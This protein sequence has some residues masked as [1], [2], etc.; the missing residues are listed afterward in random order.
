MSLLNLLYGAVFG[1][2]LEN[3][4]L[5]WQNKGRGDHMKKQCISAAIALLIAENAGAPAAAALTAVPASID[6]SVA[7]LNKFLQL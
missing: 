2:M 7:R 3:G 6:L 4:C 5:L 1:K